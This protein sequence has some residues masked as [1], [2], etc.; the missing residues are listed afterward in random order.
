MWPDCENCPLGAKYERGE[1]SKYHVPSEIRPG[2]PLLL[3]EAPGAEECPAQKPFVGSAGQ[4]L[5]LILEDLGFKRSDFSLANVLKCQP[6]NNDF[7]LGGQKA[8][9]AC[10]GALRRD[11]QMARAPYIISLGSRASRVLLRPLKKQPP[12]SQLRG[13]QFESHLPEL[14]GIP[15]FPTY[16]PSYLHYAKGD[17]GV[18]E[19][20]YQDLGN[21][22]Q[23]GVTSQ[24]VKQVKYRLVDSDE[25]KYPELVLDTESEVGKPETVRLTGYA[26]LRGGIVLTTGKPPIPEAR[27][28]CHFARH[29]YTALR[30]LG[31]IKKGWRGQ[32]EDTILL[33]QMLDENKDDYGLKSFAADRGYGFYWKTTHAR[34]DRSEDPPM[35]ELVPY[36]ATDVA[37]TRELYLE[38]RRELDQFP[39]IKRNYLFLTDQIKLLGEVELNGMAISKD[40]VKVGRNL[41]LRIKRRE[42][43]IRKTYELD[44]KVK[45]RGHAQKEILFER[46][47]LPVRKKTKKRKDPKVDKFTLA[48][49]RGED[50]TGTVR[51]Y[52]DLSDL[53]ARKNDIEKLATAAGALLHPKFNLGGRGTKNLNE[54][55][56][57]VTGRLSGQDPNPQ[58]IPKWARRY[59]IS[60]FPQGRILKVDAKQI[61]IKAA[62][63]YSRDPALIEGDV[64]SST[65]ELMTALGLLLPKGR[66]KRLVRRIFD[67]QEGKTANFAVIYYAEEPRLM[68][69]FGM[70]FDAAQEMRR[71]L[72]DHFHVHFTFLDELILLGRELGY[73]DSLTGHRRRL[74]LVKYGDKH[75]IN[76]LVNH[77]IQN[78]ANHLNLCSA[79]H[80]GPWP[81][82]CILFNLVHD[83]LVFDCPSMDHAEGLARRIDHYWRQILPIDVKRY[84]HFELA[85]EFSVEIGIGENWGETEEVKLVA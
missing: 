25:K 85:T 49:L 10:S 66:S 63:Q 24:Q 29:D 32:I 84:F 39:A 64:H 58:N 21:A 2:K 56:G 57:P 11:F 31:W 82:E 69:E 16:H 41:R 8:V 47:Q 12:I 74:P 48:A 80:L 13:H 62:Y 19:A 81:D 59:V 77:P 70:P 6:P 5:W 75:A 68:E 9:Q 83:E 76:Q 60:R 35:E 17:E 44:P 18:L 72:R 7:D 27:L 45:V 73:V 42:T 61:E 67:R 26:G 51:R 55:A 71:A 22:L 40:A 3:G 1:G 34:W 23:T 79:A 43:W 46:L 78:L 52:A 65:M 20:L 38:K 53:I 15:V 14:V 33:V 4:K 54:Q 50:P 28:I 30:R 36:C 37:L